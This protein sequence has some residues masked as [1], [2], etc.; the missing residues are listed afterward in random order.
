LGTV[1]NPGNGLPGGKVGDYLQLTGTPPFLQF[2]PVTGSPA[3]GTSVSP[4]LSP[5]GNATRDKNNI[6]QNTSLSPLL[7]LVTAELAVTA[8]TDLAV[9]VA[10]VDNVTPPLANVSDASI[11][12][13]TAFTIDTQLILFVPPGYYYTVTAQFCTGSG[14]VAIESWIEIQ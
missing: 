10:K 6:Y 7:V 4:D 11:T 9:A 5:N 13:L 3:F 8:P 12:G 2:A 1:I 14:T